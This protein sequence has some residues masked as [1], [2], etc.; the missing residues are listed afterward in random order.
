MAKT[1]YPQLHKAI[2]L[3][4]KAHKKQDLD[5]AHPLPYVTHP[6]DVL[7]LLRYDAEVLDEEILC[8]A[9]LHDLLEETDVT[10]KEIAKDFGEEVLS[11]VKQMTRKESPPEVMDLPEDK[12]WQIRNDEM[13][14]EIDHMSEAAKKIKLADRCSNLRVALRVRTGEKLERYLGQSRE[15]LEHIDREISPAL[16][17]KIQKMLGDAD[18]VAKPKRKNLRE[19]GVSGSTVTG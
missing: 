19:N 5:D 8:A 4:V 10:E 7:N 9:V 18:N 12:R 11:L 14:D 2:K 16:W 6:L 13:M 3:A 15:I 17:D 1:A